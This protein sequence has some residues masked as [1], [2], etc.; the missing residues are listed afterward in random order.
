MEMKHMVMEPKKILLVDDVITR[1]STSLGAACRISEIYPEVEVKAFAPLR[2]ISRLSD[3]N[4]MEDPKI[5]FI[6]LCDDGHGT[7]IIMN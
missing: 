6:E 1:G 2:P 7:T 3:F 5:G 4:H